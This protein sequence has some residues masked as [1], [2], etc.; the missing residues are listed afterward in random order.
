VL[1]H[2]PE[3][4]QTL[5]ER[6]GWQIP[7]LSAGRVWTDDYSNVLSVVKWGG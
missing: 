6:S 4:L 5:L 7:R 2:S 3:R 1:A